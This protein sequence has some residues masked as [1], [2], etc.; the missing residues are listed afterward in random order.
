MDFL[1]AMRRGQ[2]HSCAIDLWIVVDGIGGI[3]PWRANIY[4][5][6][7]PRHDRPGLKPLDIHP[8]IGHLG[9]LA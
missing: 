6:L 8:E 4:R 5:A 2:S 9:D 3:N 1:S 7:T